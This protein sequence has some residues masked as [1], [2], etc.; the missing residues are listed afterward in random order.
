MESMAVSFE[1]AFAGKRVLVT[2]N[3]GFKGSWLTV[4]LLELGAKVI[5]V[6]KD[7][8]TSPSM[9]EA[10]ALEQKIKHYQADI[11]DLQAMKK[12][13]GSE[14]P[15]ILFHL[16]AQPI[17]STSYDDPVDTLTSNIT[18]TA[19][20]LEALRVSDIECNA[21]IITSDKCY[22]NVEWTWGYRENDA[23]GGKDPYSASKG[24]AELVIKT[25]FHSFFSRTESKIKITSVRAGNVIGGGDWAQYRIVPDCIRAWVN[26]KSVDLRNPHATRPW[27]HVL[28]P[29]SGYLR[30]AQMLSHSRKH[31]GEAFNFGPNANQSY[32]VLQ[33]LEA[34]ADLWKVDVKDKFI[35]DKSARFH[36]AGLLK[37]NCDKAL[38]LLQWFPVLDFK[39]TAEF[40]ALWYKHYYEN[41]NAVDLY[42]FTSGQIDQYTALAKAKEI[43]WT[44]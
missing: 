25:Y 31:N 20:I 24:A 43:Q 13:I 17:V 12:I 1:N 37:L 2:G 6:S 34:I 10:L 28:E 18:G 41:S 7:I 9:F 15:D 4:W 8:P 35:L 11:R 23:L 40:T 19:N 39:H 14:Q 5:G 42:K 21:I 36:E 33:L 27:Q 26:R 29:L 38:H 16:A 44:N 3:T 22:D 30:A 32:T